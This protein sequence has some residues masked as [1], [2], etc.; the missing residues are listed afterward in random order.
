MRAEQGAV[1]VARLIRCVACGDR[2][3]AGASLRRCRCGRSLAR[4]SGDRLVVA[5][6]AKAF[7]HDPETGLWIAI[8]ATDPE[9]V[10]PTVVA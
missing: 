5:G 3:I 8:G 2:W 7:R 6:P 10:R 1:G 4:Q 9:M